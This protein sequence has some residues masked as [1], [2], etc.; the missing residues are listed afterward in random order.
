[1]RPSAALD[2][3]QPRSPAGPRRPA[4]RARYGCDRFTATVLASR[5][6]Y[7]VEHMCSRAADGAFSPILRDFYDFAATITGPPERGYPTPAMSASILLFTG[8]MTDSVAQHVEEYGLDRLAPGRRDH[9]QRPLPQRQPRQR[10][11]LHRARSSTTGGSW[12]REHE[13]APARHGRHGARAASA[14]PKPTS[15]RTASCSPRALLFREAEPVRSDVE[16]D[17]RQRPL[18]RDPRCRTC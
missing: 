9:R 15:T 17:L 8:T 6:G 12:L 2:L 14:S 11:A 5:F 3:E 7:I 1:M 18:R 16:P 13:G 10:R 4:V